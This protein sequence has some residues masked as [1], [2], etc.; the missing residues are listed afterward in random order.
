MNIL[1]TCADMRA[2]HRHGFFVPYESS[3]PPESYVET[4]TSLYV[5][6]GLRW[7]T[8]WVCYWTPT[9]PHHRLSTSHCPTPPP[10]HHHLQHT[11]GNDSV[12]WFGA[13][14]PLWQAPVPFLNAAKL[15]ISLRQCPV[16]INAHITRLKHVVMI[17]K[18]T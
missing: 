1:L 8:G 7:L 4:C 15:L 14:R 6:S 17:Q 5:F 2:S 11:I 10:R 9:K 16:T 18:V 3:Q 12:S 13:I